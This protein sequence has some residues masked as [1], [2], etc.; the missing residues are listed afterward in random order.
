MGMDIFFAIFMLFLLVY[1]AAFEYCRYKMA[2]MMAG[3]LGG[4]AVY[5]PNGSYMR[6]YYK[7]A[8]ERAWVVPDDKMAWGSS[9]SLVSPP[10]A[11]LI[12]RRS[13]A[14]GFSFQIEPRKNILFRTLSPGLKTAAFN[15]PQ[16]DKVLRLR[17]DNAIEA[18]RFF[19]VPEK[20]Q[21]L[22]ALFQAGFA[23]VKGG[24]KAVSAIMTGISQ[25]SISTAGLD[26]SFGQLRDLT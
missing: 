22:L 21:A 13:H 19:V 26:R 24:R 23:Q 3:M 6:R 16:L 15:V 11:K 14:P 2:K 12:L 10:T 18:G 1:Y 20:Q 8:E 7:D 4:R 17:A 5:K 25:K 9:P